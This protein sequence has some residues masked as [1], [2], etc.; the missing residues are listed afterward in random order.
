AITIHDVGTAV[1]KGVPLGGP[2][3]TGLRWAIARDAAIPTTRFASALVGHG[4]ATTF[5]TWLLPLVVLVADLTQRQPTVTDLVMLG[6]C[7]VVLTGSVVFWGVMLRSERVSERVAGWIGLAVARVRRHRPSWNVP[8][9]SS[10]FLEV[11]SSLRLV[12]RRPGGLLVRTAA[13]QASGAVILYVALRGL[14]VGDEL[15]VLEFARVFFVVT[16]LSS[17]VPVPG[18]IGVVEAGLTGALVAAGVAAPTALAAVLVYRLLTYVAPIVL[19]AVLYLVWRVG[20]RR[21]RPD[22]SASPAVV[23]VLS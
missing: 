23:P 8:D 2:L 15:G 21:R 19:G 17:F 6:V 4:V 11:R 10:A 14:G 22:P 16:L 9:V 3:A 18:G 20:V 13:A 12:A 1:T 7:V 5:A